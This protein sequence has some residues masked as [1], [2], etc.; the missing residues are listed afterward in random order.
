MKSSQPIFVYSSHVTISNIAP[1]MTLG[2]SVKAQSQIVFYSAI[3]WELFI[4][5][6]NDANVLTETN[7]FCMNEYI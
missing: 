4:K 5:L 3:G 1:K 6:L 7:Y 2:G